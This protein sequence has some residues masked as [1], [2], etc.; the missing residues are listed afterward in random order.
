MTPKT[1]LQLCK[2]ARE[3][4]DSQFVLLIDEISRS[5]VTRVFGEALTYLEPSKRGREF[6]LQSGT[7]TSIPQNIFV[8]AT[9]NPWDRGV[10]ELDWAIER[11]FAKVDVPPDIEVLALYCRERSYPPHVLEGLLRFF[12]FL[13]DHQNPQ[14]KVGHAYFMNSNMY[15][16]DALKRLWD[17]Q[18]S[19]HLRK[20]LGRDTDEFDRV[21]VVWKQQVEQNLDRPAAAAAGA[22]AVAPAEAAAPA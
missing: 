18:L 8:L 20:A 1:L 17:F 6:T 15:D 21:R 12:K 19:H 5:D 4:A 10:D 13:Q 22:P 14:C 3:N 2:T 9:M 7:K 16:A 11:R